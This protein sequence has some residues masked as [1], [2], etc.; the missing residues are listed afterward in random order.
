MT[1]SWVVFDW[2]PLAFMVQEPFKSGC[3][4]IITCLWSIF[5]D[6]NVL[7]VLPFTSIDTEN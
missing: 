5:L 1:W 7:Q 3:W 2:W 4:N 6:G